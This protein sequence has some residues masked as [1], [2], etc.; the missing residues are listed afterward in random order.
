MYCILGAEGFT[1]EEDQEMLSRIEKQLKRRFA[2][3][4]QVSEH[5]IVQ[6]FLKQVCFYCNCYGFIKFFCDNAGCLDS[7][8]LKVSYIYSILLYLSL[9]LLESSIL[10]FQFIRFTF[11]S[12][13]TLNEPCTKCCTLWSAEVNYNIVCSGRCCIGWSKSGYCN[14]MS[15]SCTLSHFCKTEGAFLFFQSLCVRWFSSKGI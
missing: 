2:I 12:R 13:N 15:P 10:K 9:S 6:D 4:S 7:S 11:H 8:S 5:A 3:G 1:T 14:Q